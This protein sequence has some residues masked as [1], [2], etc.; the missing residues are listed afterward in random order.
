MMEIVRP[1]RYKECSN[2]QE[3]NVLLADYT[4]GDAIVGFSQI[5]LFCRNTDDEGKEIFGPKVAMTIKV[6]EEG[7]VSKF[8]GESKIVACPGK[9]A[10]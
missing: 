10:A 3:C 2:C 1:R 9:I 5:L 7:P 4:S 6:R 8:Y